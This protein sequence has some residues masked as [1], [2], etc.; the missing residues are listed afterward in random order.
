MVMFSFFK[1]HWLLNDT[2]CPRV[3]A[4][5]LVF[6]FYSS[7]KYYLLAIYAMLPNYFAYWIIYSP[8]PELGTQDTFFS[9]SHCWFV[10][11]TATSFLV[12]FMTWKSINTSIQT[13]FSRI[14]YSNFV[15]PYVIISLYV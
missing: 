3:A 11:H 12:G 5:L 6:R 15:K 13:F 7:Y 9:S 14:Q 8:R 10:F 1:Y 4:S 2:S